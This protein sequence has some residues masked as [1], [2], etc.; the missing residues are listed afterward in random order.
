[1]S[2]S[3]TGKLRKYK[4]VFIGDQSVGKTSIISRFQFDTF[5]DHY[6]ASDTRAERRGL[7]SLAVIAVVSACQPANS[8]RAP[9][10]QFIFTSA[11]SLAL[12]RRPSGL[13][14]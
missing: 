8:P 2:S 10:F 9:R 11:R 7:G 13:I 6:Q 4:L 5:D 1:M 14:L 12:R 3:S